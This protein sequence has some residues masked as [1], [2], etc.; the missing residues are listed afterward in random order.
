M[1][2]FCWEGN[3]DPE[4]VPQPWLQITAFSRWAARLQFSLFHWSAQLSVCIKYSKN[5]LCSWTGWW[6]QFFLLQ[7]NPHFSVRL[8]VSCKVPISGEPLEPLLDAE[9]VK[10]CK[11]SCTHK[12][13]GDTGAMG[14]IPA[15]S[16][17]DMPARESTQ[18]QGLPSRTL[19]EGR[20][21]S[22]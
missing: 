18:R 9:K 8:F 20:E 14:C 4:D 21:L 5:V 16:W 2:K 13:G 10:L 12:E 17:Q 1:P 19:P 6:F 22:T 3:V 15:L 7:T 11:L